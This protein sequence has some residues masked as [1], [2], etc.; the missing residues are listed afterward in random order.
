MEIKYTVRNIELSVLE[1][2]DIEEC[3]KPSKQGK[4]KVQP[5]HYHLPTRLPQ[6]PSYQNKPDKNN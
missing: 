6:E 1:L 3:Q 4:S 2:P 5:Q